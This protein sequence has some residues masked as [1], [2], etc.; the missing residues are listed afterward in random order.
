MKSE[1]VNLRNGRRWEIY[2]AGKGSA[3][4]WLHGLR[5]VDAADPVL[6]KLASRHRL[7]APVAPGFND[8]D[9]L[10]QVDTIHDLV[11][12]YDD[13]LAELA[14]EKFDLV[15]HSFGAMV[16]AEIAAHF[17]AR[18]ARLVL[19]APIGLWNDAYPVTDIFA[20]PYTEI[21][22]SLWRD[23]N[24]RDRIAKPVA[25]NLDVKEAADQMINLA[26]SLTAV[27]KFTWPIPDRGLRRRL[28]R[29]AAP[30]LALFG[31]DDTVVSPR[32]AD[33]L[34]GGLPTAETK[35]IAGG[36]H[37]LTYER[38]AE[39]TAHLERFLSP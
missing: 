38:P 16:A 11:L 9:E 39:V 28:P 4:V 26:R 25:P 2:T 7:I 20:I 21:D 37:M 6:E 13:L 17:P 15:G 3:L 22:N 29:I 8:L 36:G 10:A 30:T 12:D 27:T 33:D 31:E 35:V 1:I 32:Y 24:A 14:L 34:R 23:Q 19:L 18:V 5:G